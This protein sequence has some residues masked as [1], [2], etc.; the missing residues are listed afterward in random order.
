LPLLAKDLTKIPL[1]QLGYFLLSFA[2]VLFH[3]QGFRTLLYF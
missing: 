3:D 2:L 1:D